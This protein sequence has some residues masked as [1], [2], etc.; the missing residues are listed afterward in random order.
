MANT[1]AKPPGRLGDPNMSPAT[2]PRIHPGILSA[3]KFFGLEQYSS[4]ELPDHSIDALTPIIKASEEGVMGLY[5]G[6]ENDLPGDSEEGEVITT[7]TTIKGF[8]GNDILLYIIKPASASAGRPLPGIVYTHGGGMV[9]NT[10]SNRVHDRWVKS[11]ALQNTIVVMPDF[12]NAYTAAGHNPFPAGL[13][14][15]AAAAQYVAS[16]RSELGISNLILQGES[17][18]GNLAIATALKAKREGWISSVS[19]VYAIVPFISNGY[20]W[21]R[22]RKLAELPSLI[23]NEGYW[24][25]TGMIAAVGYYYSPDH[26]DDPHAWPYH[27]SIDDLKGLPP[28]MLTM[29]ELDPLRDEGI[30]FY[31]KLLAAGVKVAASVS[32]GTVH[33]SG[34]GYR[35][36]HPEN[37]NAVVRSVG[38]FAH[39]L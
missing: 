36:A 22:E 18:G 21:S 11:L 7:T 33:G 12:R 30:A 2:D 27:S 10:T 38:A 26:M 6:M 37:Y 24:L 28:V 20:A 17:G 1:T 19:G 8:D 14:D 13:N 4:M 31:R 35:K 34:V 15:C 32:L 5:E 39:S 25:S 9:M 16:H 3:L 29:D 23:E